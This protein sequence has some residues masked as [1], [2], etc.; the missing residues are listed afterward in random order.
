MKNLMNCNPKIIKEDAKLSEAEEIMRRHNIKSLLV[1]N[2][3]K[4]LVGVI[5]AFSC[6]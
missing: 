4:K 6:L 1:V 5:D 3:E 2:D